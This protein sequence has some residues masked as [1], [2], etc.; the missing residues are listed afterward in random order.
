MDGQTW[1]VQKILNTL[2]QQAEALIDTPLVKASVNLAI[3]EQ[4]PTFQFIVYNLT[5]NQAMVAKAI[6]DEGVVAAPYSNE[7]LQKHH[8][9]AASSVK[10]TIKTLEK[11]QLLYSIPEKGLIVY[12]RFFAIWLRRQV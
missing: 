10:R 11:Q 5:P 12:D 3:L 9:P 4:E 8:L 1:Y 6:A 7:F 2:Y